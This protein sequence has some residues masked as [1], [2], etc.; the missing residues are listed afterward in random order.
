GPGNLKYLTLEVKE[1]I[2]KAEKIVA[3][4]RVSNSLKNIRGDIVEIKRIDEIIELLN[5][6]E[7]VLILASG[8]P[9]F[10]G[11]VEYLKK[12]NI[13][14][15]MIMPGISS[16]QYMMVK[17]GLSWQGA[18]LISLHGRNEGLESV[19]KHKLSIILTDSK[20]TPSTISKEI[21][22]LGIRGKIY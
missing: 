1:T 8:D 14:I 18:N 5:Q 10:Y 13:P 4:G 19:K 16:F 9:C 21:Y 12:K 22:N 7:N 17:L 3:F 20:N 6:N 11:I 15:E 2:E